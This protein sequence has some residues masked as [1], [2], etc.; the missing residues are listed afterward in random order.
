MPKHAVMVSRILPRMMTLQCG[1]TV[2][3]SGAHAGV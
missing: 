2:E 3:L 1:L